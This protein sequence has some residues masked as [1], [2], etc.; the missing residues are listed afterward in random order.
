[1]K[2]SIIVPLYNKQATIRRALYSALDQANI[3]SHDVEIVVVDDGS[4]DNSVNQVKWVQQENPT[5]HIT[6]VKQSNGGVSA[7]RNLGGALAQHDYITFLDADD[8]YKPTFLATIQRLIKRYPNS[9]FYA[10]AYEFVSTHAGTREPAKLAL[11]QQHENERQSDQLLSDF[12]ISA[13]SGDLPF[14]SSSICL[15]KDLF[16]HLGGFP[17]GENMG[18]DQSLFC[19]VAL[20]HNIAYSAEVCASYF[21]GI[22]GSLMQTEQA[23]KEMPFSKRLQALLDNQEVP[24][25]LEASIKKYISGHLLDLVRR[26]FSSGNIN[27]ANALLTDH[28]AKAKLL[29]WA[30]WRGR[31][32]FSAGP[33]LV[34][35]TH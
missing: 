4:N 32:L 24:H 19:Q 15:H 33:R 17:E 12:F 26:N 31:C 35:S 8:T 18:E 14:C 9:Y 16:E 20:K 28:R 10:T 27:A 1:M 29:R 3:A 23:I 5:R 6:L 21:L 2:F 30:F 7:A 25:S 34:R 22:S 13:A 11:L